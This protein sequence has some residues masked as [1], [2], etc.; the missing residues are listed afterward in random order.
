MLNFWQWFGIDPL[1]K[2]REILGFFLIL[3]QSQMTRIT[4]K[5]M[6]EALSCIDITHK[7][8]HLIHKTQEIY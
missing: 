1:E 7:K 3:N 5:V 2:T 4:S 8:K 6:P